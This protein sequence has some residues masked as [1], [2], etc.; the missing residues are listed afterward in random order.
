MAITTLAAASSHEEEPT[1]SSSCIE[2]RWMHDKDPEGED[3]D[4][5]EDE[6]GG[7]VELKLES[8]LKG[9]EIKQKE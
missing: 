7:N 6:Q 1:S 2:V 8:K 3:Y 9:L 5:E 4:D